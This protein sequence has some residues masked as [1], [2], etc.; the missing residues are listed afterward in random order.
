MKKADTV[1]GGGVSV[2]WSTEVGWEYIVKGKEFV[3]RHLGVISLRKII[4]KSKEKV[5]GKGKEREE[6][7]MGAH[8][9]KALYFLV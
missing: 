4:M 6:V 3:H 1:G 9:Y 5:S 8:V 2:E 7:P